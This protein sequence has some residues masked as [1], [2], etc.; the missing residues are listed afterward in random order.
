MLDHVSH[1]KLSLERLTDLLSY[2]PAQLFGIKNKGQ[3]KVGFDAD[4]TIVDLNKEK[5]ITNDWIAS[6]SGWTAFDG[7][8]VKGWPTHTV[9]NGQ[10]VMENDQL[11]KLGAGRP[12][13]FS[14]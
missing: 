14:K 5:T 7:K 11:F 3:I 2:N 10:V 8:K 4:F 13:E 12:L 6:K 9:I 1:N